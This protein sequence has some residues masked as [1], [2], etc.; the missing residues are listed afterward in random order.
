MTA[1]DTSRENY[2]K[3]YDRLDTLRFQVYDFIC[4]EPGS[5]DITIARSLHKDIN[6][7][8]PRVTELIGEGL[9]FA[10]RSTNMKGNTARRTFPRSA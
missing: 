3:H 7:I 10:E 9:V 8:T 6:S 4:R 2:A 5:D 1:A